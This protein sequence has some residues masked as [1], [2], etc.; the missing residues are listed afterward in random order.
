[1]N[2]SLQT[3]ALLFLALCL[4]ACVKEKSLPNPCE[5]TRLFQVEEL[6]VL[7]NFMPMST[8][9]YWIYSDSIFMQSGGPAVSER[10][11][12][13][14]QAFTYAQNGE[15]SPLMFQGLGMPFLPDLAFKGDTVYQLNNDR[16]LRHGDCHTIGLP[17]LFPVDMGDT[18]WVMQRDS[19]M[20]R[21]Y[22]SNKPVV[23]P[24]G[25]FSDNLVLERTL[26]NITYTF[27]TEVGLIELVSFHDTTSSR[28]ARRLLLQEF[29]RGF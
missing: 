7:S 9:F 1:M 8:R 25:I 18:A 12:T 17:F 22:R 19:S 26:P 27:N 24:L 23:T 14:R 29:N 15:N 10:L 3:R 6:Q 20:A 5:A 2:H 11:V 21:L 13:P 4:G 16:M 28:V